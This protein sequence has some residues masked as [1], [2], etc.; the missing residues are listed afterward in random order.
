MSSFA[1]IALLLMLFVFIYALLGMS[2]FGGKLTF[3]EN[4]P[5]SNFDSFHN[6]FV[7]TFQLLT[8]ENWN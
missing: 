6:A 4:S 3:E 5:R 8:M 2:I 1:Y 7:I